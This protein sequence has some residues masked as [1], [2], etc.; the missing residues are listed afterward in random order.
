MSQILSPAGPSISPQTLLFFLLFLFFFFLLSFSRLNLH[1]KLKIK[2][3]QDVSLTHKILESTHSPVIFAENHATFHFLKNSRNLSF[4][5][6]NYTHSFAVNFR[7]NSRNL[8]FFHARI[9]HNAVFQDQFTRLLSPFS[10]HK[11]QPIQR[12]TNPTSHFTHLK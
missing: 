11:A 3:K 7:K 2:T 12:H 9:T 8:P 1:F 5:R 4:P 10:I 6:K